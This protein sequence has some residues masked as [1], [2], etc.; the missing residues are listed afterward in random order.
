MVCPCG[1]NYISFHDC[2]GISLSDALDQLISITAIMRL[3]Y[4]ERLSTLSPMPEGEDQHISP[5]SGTI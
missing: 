2:E 4:W 3:F 1:K 5:V